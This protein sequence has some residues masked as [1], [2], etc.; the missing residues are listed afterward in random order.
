MQ[1]T[2][3]AATTTLLLA[4]GAFAMPAQGEIEHALSKRTCGELKGT[5]LKACQ[6]V[7]IAACDAVTDLILKNFCKTACTAGPLKRSDT[8]A[9]PAPK[10][11]I[12]LDSITADDLVVLG[13]V[14][15]SK[16]NKVVKRA[17]SF[18]KEACIAGCEVL[19]NS[20]VLAL[21][22]TKCLSEC[23]PKCK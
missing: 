15:G 7:C 10:A 6:T 17:P 13:H 16:E 4:S 11:P 5:P 19:C 12:S 18:G 23:K 8:H 14:L 1:I 9:T 20:T 3:I 22:Q 21:A 2:S